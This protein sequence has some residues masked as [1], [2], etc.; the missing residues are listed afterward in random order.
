[1]THQVAGLLLIVAAILVTAKLLGE[2][3]ERLGLPAVLGELV[4][5]LVLG[6]G[7]LGVL[8]AA[9]E[10]G[11]EVI[12][13][14]AELGVILLL[15]EVGLETDLK[16]MLKVGSSATAVAVVGVIVPF[17][18]G[19]LYWLYIPHA[20][21]SSTADVNSIA[22]LV[23]AVLTATSVGITARVLDDLGCMQTVEARIILGAAVIDDVLGLVILG[24]VSG[25][26]DGG[27]ISTLG[28]LRI[29]AEGVGF[30]VVTVVLGRLIV[31]RLFALVNRLKVRG[32]VVTLAIASTFALAA[33]ADYAGS[34]LIIGA[35]AAGLLMRDSDQ[36]HTIARE[37]RPVAGLLAPIFFV[38]VGAGANI[39]L[40]DPR[41]PA[42]GPI[43][44]LAIA[45]TLIAVVGKIVAG[46]AAP[47]QPF[48]RLA[49]GVG[50]VPRGEVGLIFADMGRRT[51]ILDTASFSAIL[52]VVMATTFIA[53]FGLKLLLR[54]AR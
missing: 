24:G 20:A 52:I 41:L 14:L 46:W 3:A 19:Y 36:L 13:F 42:A 1:M 34:A 12:S 9:G 17:V 43:L 38:T 33:A 53:P 31:P 6:P 54:R 39:R 10:P 18:L 49:V 45:L 30:L 51:G 50:M 48:R 7:L 11:A 35:F 8:P 22:I 44:S 2:V 29:L 16:Q 15:F 27:S 4:A 5:G 21:T 32:A 23:G 26:T 47:W 37:G 25:L 40:L 28:L